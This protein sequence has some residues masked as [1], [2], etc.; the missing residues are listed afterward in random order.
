L[1]VTS[2]DCHPLVKGSDFLG[3]TGTR[4]SLQALHPM[5]K[6]L[7]RGNE[8]SLPLDRGVGCKSFGGPAP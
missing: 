3:K 8:Q 7:M 1:P 4:F 2:M 5:L 6:R